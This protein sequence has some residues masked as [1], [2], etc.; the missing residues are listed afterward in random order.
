MADERLSNVLGAPFEEFVLT[1]L[2]VRAARNSTGGRGR[3]I[4]GESYLDTR[5]TDEVLFL[6]NKMAWVKLTSSVRVDFW[7]K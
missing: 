7:N 5:S 4:A 2:N 3:T 6:A 1:Q